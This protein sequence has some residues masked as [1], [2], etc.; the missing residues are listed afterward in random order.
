MADHMHDILLKYMSQ[1]DV[2]LY[3]LKMELEVDNSGVTE[4][5]E[6]SKIDTFCFLNQ[7]LLI[8]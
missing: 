7:H 8:Y 2:N 4:R 3:Q 1:L 6:K 5:I